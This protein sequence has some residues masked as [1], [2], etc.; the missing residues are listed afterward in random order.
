MTVNKRVYEAGELDA[1]LR[2]C[3]PPTNDDVSVTTDGRRLDTPEA[4]IEFFEDLRRNGVEPVRA[5]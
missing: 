3:P 2:A 4:V 1:L 5:Q